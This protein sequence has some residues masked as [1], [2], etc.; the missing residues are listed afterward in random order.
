ML[1]YLDNSATTAPCPEAME[2]VTHALE[3]SWGNPSS[4]HGAGIKAEA[5]LENSRRTIAEKL[6]C[7]SDEI[8]FTSGGTEGNNLLIT[9]AAKARQRQGRRIVATAVEHPSVEA[10]LRQ[11]EN[12]GFELVLLPADS[13]GK[14]SEKDLFESVNKDTILISIMA[15]NNEVGSFQPVSAAKK[16]VAAAGAPAL[17]HCDAVQAF[18]KIPFNPHSA[19]ADLIT[20]SAHKIH[21]PKGAGAVFVKSGVHITPLTF[22]GSQEKALRPGT[23]L[24]PAI[25]GFA[26]A[27]KALPDTGKEL[28]RISGLRD[29]FLSELSHIP[30]IAVNSPKDGLAYI[31]NI[32]VPGVLAAHMVNFLSERGIYISGGSACSGG[33][34]SRTLT[35]MGLKD[36]IIKSALRISFSRFTRKEDIDRLLQGLTD[37][38]KRFLH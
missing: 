13:E 10:P 2:A 14:I 27:A 6:G 7:S 37:G 12:D 19:G 26:A 33:K 36:E 17:V 28:V 25:A 38:Q 9:G 35:A 5:L 16:A 29:Y 11:L 22:G 30:N 24:M 3:D 23:Q 8:Y 34:K 31:V 32:S 1:I 15:V 18:G 20:L 4:P 21:G